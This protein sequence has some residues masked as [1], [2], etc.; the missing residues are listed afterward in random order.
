MT[1]TALSLLL[2]AL[3]LCGLEE[4][5]RA[6]R[7]YCA[8]NEC[9]ALFQDPEDYAGAQKSCKDS[10]GQLSPYMHEYFRKTIKS[11]VSGSF[12]FKG[13]ADEC[14]QSCCSV[15]VSAE[16]DLS[17]KEKPC[18]NTLDGFVCQYTLE[19][20]CGSLQAG[21]G[22]QVRYSQ[23]L[24]FDLDDSETFPRGTI[25]V[26]EKLGGK[27]PDSKHVCFSS[28]W[29]RAPW[30]C[31]VLKGGC[32][33]ECTS[34]SS[35]THTCTCP[36]GKTLHANKF[37]CTDGPCALNPCKDEG[38]KCEVSEGGFNCTCKDGFVR[39]DGVCVNVTICLKCEH[40]M[41]DK[42]NGVYECGCRKG[43]RVSAHD[44]TKCEV[45]CT[46]R[47]CP[48]IRSEDKCFCPEGYVKDTPD[49]TNSQ[50]FCTD[51]D[52]CESDRCDQKCENSYGSYRCS[53]DENFKLDHDEHTCVRIED[54]EEGSGFTPSYPAPPSPH[55]AV[56]PSYIKTGSVLGITVF[57][58]LCAGLLFF[59]IR[60]AIKRCGKF[61]LSSIKHADIFYLQQVTTET[62]K[63]LSFDKPFKN[64]SQILK[65]QL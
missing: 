57:M 56:V 54:N 27:Y 46:G 44:P 24:D 49:T 6:H 45:I 1:S 64:D 13:K 29:I 26:A 10:G 3:F 20:P 58:A 31:E 43:F 18:S 19:E 39:E 25:A 53:C 9:F 50:P 59:L 30:N 33:Q 42:V 35:K 34:T 55:P 41:C 22:A 12:W 7:G 23:P 2:C 40:M 38:E 16:Q 48:C 15:S 63:R 14:N 4:T 52:E 11:P 62:Y 32:E 28:R 51:I 36:A 5:V 37:T 17:T 65:S 60:N 8:G 47:D 61:E 21:E